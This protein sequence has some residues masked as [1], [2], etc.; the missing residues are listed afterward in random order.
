MFTRSRSRSHTNPERVDVP[1]TAAMP[2]PAADEAESS[3]WPVPWPLP[4]AG[5]LL[6]CEAC[7]A[8]RDWLL[9]RYREQIFVRCRCAHEW[10]EPRLP[11]DWYDKHCGP[12]DREYPTC[13][14]AYRAL[15]FDG[16][17]AGT[18]W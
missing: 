13:D 5:G 18:Y 10:A 4:L 14:D 12:V 15:G 17:L 3:S 1:E 16:T 9:L 6:T 7:R 8:E 11:V 2:R